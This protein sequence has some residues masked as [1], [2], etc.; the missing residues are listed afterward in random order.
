V[1]SC[2]A[3]SWTSGAEASSHRR[4]RARS[5]SYRSHRVNGG[6]F[7]RETTPFQSSTTSRP[8]GFA[9]GPTSL[10][11]LIP[12]TAS[13]GLAPWLKR[14]VPSSLRLR[15]QVFSTSQRFLH[16]QTSRPCFVP[17]AV[18]EIH[19][20]ECSPHRNRAPLSRPHAPLQLS[21]GVPER[22]SRRLV[23]AGFGR[24]PRSHAVAWLPPA[25]MS[26]LSPRRSATPG[27][28]GPRSVEPS[29]SATFT[30]FEALILLRV[31]SRRVGLPL[32]DGRY[33]PGSFAPLK[34]SPSSPRILYPRAP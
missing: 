26:S 18:R 20:P 3:P 14:A 24:L 32:L 25:T 15:S 29:R 30:C 10:R 5:D 34:P 31:R 17:Q 9:P 7:F 1:C 8:P 21:T 33:S 16:V 13:L 23:T 19:P 11:F 4:A 27:R 22:T 12:S 2:V 28:P 6:S